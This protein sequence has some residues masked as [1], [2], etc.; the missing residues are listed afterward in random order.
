MRG[1]ITRDDEFQILRNMGLGIL[2]EQLEKA[3]LRVTITG[4]EHESAYMLVAS[5]GFHGTAVM[6]KVSISPRGRVYLGH[7][8]VKHLYYNHMLT[9]PSWVAQLVDVTNPQKK[10]RVYSQRPV[11]IDVF[12]NV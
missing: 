7:E 6:P 12:T 5:V 1:K 10:K 4:E 11:T 2:P 9:P 3:V 8:R